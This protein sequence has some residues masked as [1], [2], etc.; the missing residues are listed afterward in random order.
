MNYIEHLEAHCGESTGHLEMEELQDHAIQMLQFQNAPFANA[1]TV[2]S[3]GLLHHPLQFENG[4]V[5]HQEVMLSVMQQD[6][7]SDLI[8]LIYRLTLEALKTGHAYDLGEYLPMPVGLLSKYDFAALY[9]TTPFYFEESFQVYKGNAAFGE[10]ETV[11]PVWFVPIFASEVAYIEQ[12]GTEE[13]NEMLYETEMQL[14]NL[15]RHPLVGD[16]EEIEESI[17]NREV[18]VCECEI[19]GAL[20]EDDIQR[21][22]VLN[23]P[24]AKAYH[25]SVESGE[26]GDTDQNETFL[27]DFL[28]H[29][30]RFPIYATFFA[31]E[32]EDKQNKAF[33][34]QHNMS[35]T[36]HV[37]SRQKQSN[38]WLRGKRTSTSESHFFT[39]KIENARM[40]ELILEHAYGVASMDELF[41][42]SYSDRLSIQQEVETTYRKTRVLE[43]RFVYPED[44]TV[45]IVGH[46]GTMLYLLSN[47]EHF[48]YDLRTDWAKRLR[49]QLPNDTIIRQLNGELFADL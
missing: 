33:F 25:V 2:T 40:L 28:N 13:F 15:K 29:Q 6:A 39:V 48:A 21:P 47:E 1:N 14:L 23:G 22:L 32:E 5:V 41:M 49:Q 35:F 31:F 4:S 46:D 37:L 11:L 9:V 20:F 34:M 10:P 19:T 24:L 26:Q 43:D 8:E 27:F 36:S 42:F 30:N 16:N 17:F 45:V 3:L 7:E 18:F 38:G 44:T 12:Y